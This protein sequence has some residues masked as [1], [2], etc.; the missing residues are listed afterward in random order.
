MKIVICDYPNVLNRDLEYEKSI[1]TK[2][3][4]DAEVVVHEYINEEDFYKA[5]KDADGVLTAFIDFDKKVLDKA[6]NMKC[7]SINACGYQNVDIEEATR[8]NIAVCAIGEYC[9]QEVAEHT[10][11]LILALTRNIKHYINDIDKKHL[12]QY[13]SI[14]TS[15]RI[16]GQVLGI[17]GFGKIG[18]AVAKR[19][20]A[21]GMEVIIVDPYINS[22]V[23]KELNVKIVT[24]EY[25]FENADI[26]TNHMNQSESNN[27]Y[28]TYDKFK[29]FKRKPLFIN[30]ARGTSVNEE[31]LIKTLEEGLILGAGLDVLKAEDPD[32]RN[33]PLVNRENVIITPHSAFY[34]EKSLQELQRISCENMVNYFNKDYDKLFR[35]INEE[36]IA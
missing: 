20:Q 10:L 24:P 32:L 2:G 30:V 13:S 27:G 29:M 35:I 3:I 36:V 33:N 8:K 14:T 21:F 16:E 5:I 18:R 11:T 19:A 17:F 34:S 9:T 25:I 6:K 31:D 22:E 7:I 23:E 4:K 12:W 26:I 1:I 28:F 15:R